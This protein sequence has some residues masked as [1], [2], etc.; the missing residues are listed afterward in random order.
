M[1]HYQMQD[2]LEGVHDQ[3]NWKK[4]LE[5]FFE[6]I[7]QM[8]ESLNP[9]KTEGMGEESR[10]FKNHQTMIKHAF[11]FKTL[12]GDCKRIVPPIVLM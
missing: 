5:I 10:L 4:W 2:W 11:R 1:F 6:G 12:Q 9:K 7:N 8:W 3:T